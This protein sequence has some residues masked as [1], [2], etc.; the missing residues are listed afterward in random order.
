[1]PL[2]KMPHPYNDGGYAVEDFKQVDPE[3]G[4]NEEMEKLI[5]EKIDRLPGIV[6][7]SCSTILSRIKDVKGLRL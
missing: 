5:V 1:M 7:C 6:A 4:T 3:I 2:L